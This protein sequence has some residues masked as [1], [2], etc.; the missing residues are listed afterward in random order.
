MTYMIEPLF[1]DPGLWWPLRSCS[2]SQVVWPS[3]LF[4][5][6]MELVPHGA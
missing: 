5:G 1:T 2:P 6:D 3:A 4:Q